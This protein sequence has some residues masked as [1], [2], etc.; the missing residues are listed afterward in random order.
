MLRLTELRSINMLALPSNA[1]IAAI[2]RLIQ[3]LDLRQMPHSNHGE[4]TISGGI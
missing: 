2:L 1:M 3:H 4:K